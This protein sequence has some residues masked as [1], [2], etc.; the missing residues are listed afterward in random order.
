MAKV[1]GKT[2]MRRR[3]LLLSVVTLTVGLASLADEA[4]ASDVEDVKAADQ[5]FHAALSAMDGQTMAGLWAHKASVTNI[6]PGSKAVEVGF[7]DAVSKWMAT[8]VPGRY[9]ELKAQMTS[10]AAVE[11]NGNVAWVVGMESVSGKTK[12]GEAISFDAMVTDIF[13][14][15]GGKWLMVSHHA[16]RPPK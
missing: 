11:V 14:K 15:D 4:L 13:E 7:E 12:T 8:T 2:F 16:Q 6:G 5:A 10:F 1:D 3:T 9:S